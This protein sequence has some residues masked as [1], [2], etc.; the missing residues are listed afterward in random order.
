M[1]DR[2]QICRQL[3]A[4]IMQR[5][6][7]PSFSVKD[8][9]NIVTRS[10][11]L[12]LQ[13]HSVFFASGNSGV[14]G[15]LFS[16]GFHNCLSPNSTIFSPKWPNN[17][18]YVTNVGAIKVYLNHS[19]HDPESAAVDPFGKPWA[20]AYSSSGGS[21]NIYPQPDYQ[22]AAI[23]KYFRDHKSPYSYYESK[24]NSSFGKYGGLYNRLGRA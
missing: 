19:V 9:V 20:A 7:V 12:G 23:D 4:K 6:R 3:R 5:V 18:P 14:A 2:K 11:K 8:V 10:M 24:G 21:S 16:L 15:P 17:C 1:G 13:G 22:K